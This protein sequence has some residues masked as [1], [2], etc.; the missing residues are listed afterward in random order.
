M[1]KVPSRKVSGV[2]APVKGEVSL[3]KISSCS[4]VVSQEVEGGID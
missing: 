2:W 4:F 1:Q 3:S